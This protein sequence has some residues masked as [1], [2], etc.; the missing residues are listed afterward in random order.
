[1]FMGIVQAYI[2]ACEH[3]HINVYPYMV[4]DI[5]TYLQEETK[6]QQQENE[7]A[8]MVVAKR[9]RMLE[10]E[11][12]NIERKPF[13]ELQNE[14]KRFRQDVFKRRHRARALRNH[15]LSISNNVSM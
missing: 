13:M 12:E 6:R 9:R 15:G 8:A 3:I 11:K 5:E 2:L 10:R 14:T 1:M 7:T 4:H